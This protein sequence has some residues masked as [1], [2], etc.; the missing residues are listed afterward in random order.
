M[1]VSYTMDLYGSV[2]TGDWTAKV[3][4]PAWA[5]IVAVSVGYI[6]MAFF[7]A[8][9]R[10]ALICHWGGVRLSLTWLVR[11]RAAID[12][13]ERLISFNKTWIYICHSPWIV[14]GKNKKPVYSPFQWCLIL[15]DHVIIKCAFHMNMG[16]SQRFAKCTVS[17][18]K[19]NSSS[20][21][22]K[23]SL[24]TITIHF[25]ILQTKQANYIWF[26]IL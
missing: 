13:L 4:N 23:N 8:G 2:K 17:V 5:W 15:N 3:Q 24:M 25:A 21:Q 6:Y 16:T 26:C 18:I 14:I 7:F 9:K 11:S 20:N 1:C 12:W 22:M 10:R 19:H